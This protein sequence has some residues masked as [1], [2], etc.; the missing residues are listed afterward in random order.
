M[1]LLKVETNVCGG[2]ANLG[3]ADAS[4]Y[5]CHLRSLRGYEADVKTFVGLPAIPVH[6]KAMSQGG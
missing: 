3:Q 6:E 1:V 4:D 2:G 5:I